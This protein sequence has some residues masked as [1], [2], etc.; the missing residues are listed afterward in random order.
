[1]RAARC[2][3]DNNVLAMRLAMNRTAK[4][5]LMASTP[6]SVTSG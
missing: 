1:L 6:L 4:A 3:G 2:V 5:A